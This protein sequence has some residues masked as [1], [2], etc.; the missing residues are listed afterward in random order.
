MNPHQLSLAKQ[1]VSNV[2]NDCSKMP[3]QAKANRDGEIN[4]QN[5]N[6]SEL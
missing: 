2:E 5:Y 1:K 3:N 4:P 6:F